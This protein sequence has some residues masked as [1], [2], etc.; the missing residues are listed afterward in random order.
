MLMPINVFN[1][2]WN[3]PIA[4]PFLVVI[5][6]LLPITMITVHALL[7]E[8]TVQDVLIIPLVSSVLMDTMFSMEHAYNAQ[9]IAQHA[10][11]PTPMILMEQTKQIS[12]LIALPV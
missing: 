5:D 9:S 11:S 1:V 6:V 10:N 4:H 2:Q 3:A 8:L 12:L 7:V